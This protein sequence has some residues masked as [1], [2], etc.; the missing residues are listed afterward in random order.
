MIM[1]ECVNVFPFAPNGGCPGLKIL[2]PVTYSEMKNTLIY[3]EGHMR[4][5]FL[6][7]LRRDLRDPQHLLNVLFNPL[8]SH[9]K[10]RYVARPPIKRPSYLH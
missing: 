9:I 2:G 1:K 8:F 10:K 7:S 5:T 4:S 3:L 6:P